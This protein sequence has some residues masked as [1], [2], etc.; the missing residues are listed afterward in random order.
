MPRTS[1][2]ESLR[3]KLGFHTDSAA[4]EADSMGGSKSTARKPRR[5]RTEKTRSFDNQTF[6]SQPFAGWPTKLRTTAFSVLNSPPEYGTSVNSVM[7]GRDRPSPA[8]CLDRRNGSAPDRNPAPM[9]TARRRIPEQL[10]A[11]YPSRPSQAD[12]RSRSGRRR[13]RFRGPF[14][15]RAI[16]I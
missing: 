16:R 5:P 15:E 7:A 2:V 3:R 6:G 14:G 12:G 8:G 9:D 11:R 13:H 10:D 4:E 1:L